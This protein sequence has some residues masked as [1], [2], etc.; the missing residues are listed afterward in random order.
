MLSSPSM[1]QDVSLNF[2]GVGR[3]TA[4]DAE[5][6]IASAPEAMPVPDGVKPAATG[7]L[8]LSEAEAM[9]LTF[10]PSL[11]EA[12]A[13]VRAAHGNWVQVGLK[14]N[15][16]IGYAGNE[17]GNERTAGQQGGI[18]TQEFVT[19]GKLDLNRAVAMREKAVAE[20]RL[21]QARLQ[22]V[23]TLRKYYFEAVAADKAVTLTHQLS[24]IAAKSVT[25][26]K[27]LLASGDVTQSSLLQ[28]EIESESAA[29]LEQQAA[30]RYSAARKRLATVLGTD[31]AD[32]LEDVFA[33]P[34]PELDFNTIRERI[35][36]DSPELSELRFA[37]D[38]A[39]WA[40]RR[41][42]AGRVPNMNVQAGVQYDNAAQDTIAN[43]QVTLPVPIFDRKQGAITEACGELAAAQAALQARELAIQERLTVAMRDYKMARERVVRYTE[44]ILPA[45]KDT[46]NLMS[47]GYQQG[48]L[49]YLQLLMVQQ[50]YA[51]KNLS[52]LADLET[53]W[54]RWAEIDGFLV[55]DIAPI[56][57]DRSSRSSE[58]K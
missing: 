35:L 24:E 29:L 34:L 42:S 4:S 32:S 7:T 19:G 44:K 23:I 14:P 57:I 2:P 5:P 25:T 20:Q 54:Q 10:H 3:S 46:L 28:S 56:E 55:G 16:E 52:Y 43:V 48:E 22:V 50:T 15:P 12:A 9:A 40:V 30:E 51:T 41:A 45:A 58:N 18:I 26:S 49:D 11:R 13:L 36:T 38:R 1:A 53:A 47:I 8:T 6:R 39:R 21:E 27:Q 33:R 37:V 17:I 31:E